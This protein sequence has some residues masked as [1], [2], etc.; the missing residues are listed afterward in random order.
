MSHNIGQRKC[1]QFYI[2]S[3]GMSFLQS[4]PFKRRSM[5]GTTFF[6]DSVPAMLISR[7]FCRVLRYYYDQNMP[8][9]EQVMQKGFTDWVGFYQGMV[10][11][12]DEWS[13]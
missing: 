9:M 4:L 7:Y 10:T 11:G 12:K 2:Y 6:V 3:I 13:G 8:I 1:Q 5:T